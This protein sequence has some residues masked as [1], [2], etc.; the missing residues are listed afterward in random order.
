MKVLMLAFSLMLLSACGTSQDESWVTLQT[1]GKSSDS[2]VATRH[3]VTVNFSSEAKQQEQTTQQ[4]KE[5]ITA[6]ESWAQEH[7]F[8]VVANRH[9]LRPT[10]EYSKENGRQLTGYKASQSFTLESLS[11]EGYQIALQQLPRLKPE[12]FRL[13]KV[14][15]SKQDQQALKQRLIRTAY[16][17]AEQTARGLMESG[18]LCRLAPTDI[19]VHN[20]QSVSPMMMRMESANQSAMHKSQAEEEQSIQLQVSWRAKPCS[21]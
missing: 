18:S 16:E 2:V 14:E 21:D 4:L 19:V 6:F 7:G 3:F 10:Y 13:S 15:A 20:S 17:D 5:R 12:Q 8:D 9:E 11:T 1:Q